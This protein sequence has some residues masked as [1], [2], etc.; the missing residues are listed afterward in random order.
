MGSMVGPAVMRRRFFF[1]GRDL[2]QNLMAKNFRQCLFLSVFCVG[3]Q[4]S[5]MAPG[6]NLPVYAREVAWVG[7]EVI[8]EDVLRTQLLLE[9]NKF[10]DVEIRDKPKQHHSAE[11][12]KEL[13]DL[14][15]EKIVTD[16]AIIAY[17]GKKGLSIDPK[18]L[19]ARYEER[20][21][22]A[23][24]KTIENLLSEKG[25]PYSRYKNIVETEIRVQHI[26]HQALA[27]DVQVS[28]G[29]IRN[30]YNSHTAD[31][32]VDERVRVRQIVTDSLEKAR[33]IHGRLLKGENFAKL[34]VNHSI[35]PDR[36]QGGDLGY[37]AKG[38][39]PK[40]FDENCFQLRKGELSEIV[41][42]DYGF[43]IFKLLDKKPAGTKPLAEAMP[44]IHDILYEGKL[45][46]AYERFMAKVKETVSVK[47]D[48]E[49]LENFVL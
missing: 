3:L 37:F 6:S 44:A 42:S 36:A 48:R 5:C 20:K 19:S 11:E 41:K 22:A 35:S 33:D 16:H 25:L 1:I 29:E 47:I 39:Y 15:L 43:H 24:P 2:G 46:L 10:S 9:L 17:G 30:Y 23:N 21:R 34:A 40:E 8:K 13:L 27:K 49:V 18:E 38:S 14:V 32:H 26:L 7:D 28:V 4:L 12:I 31:F 45:A